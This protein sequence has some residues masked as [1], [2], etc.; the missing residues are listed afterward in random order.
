MNSL[1][2]NKVNKLIKLIVTAI[3]E[4]VDEEICVI[5]KKKLWV[6]KRIDRRDKSSCSTYLET[7]FKVVSS[8]QRNDIFAATHELMNL[9]DSTGADMFS[10][11]T[12]EH[13]RVVGG[14]TRPK[15]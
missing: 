14:A 4:E 12:S 13:G 1:Q 6:R 7:N 2:R 9:T 15:K 3:L 8:L 11:W 10:R 5:N